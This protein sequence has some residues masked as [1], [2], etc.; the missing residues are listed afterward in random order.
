MNLA[1]RRKR[2]EAFGSVRM[3]PSRRDRRFSYIIRPIPTYGLKVTA[4]S[5]IHAQELACNSNSPAVPNPPADPSLPARLQLE[6]R[7]QSQIRLQTPSL[8]AHLSSPANPVRLLARLQTQ[9]RLQSQARLQTQFA[10]KLACRPKSACSPKV[11]CRLSSPASSPADPSLP[12]VL[13]S[14]ADPSC[15]LASSLSTAHLEYGNSYISGQI[16][17]I[18][19]EGTILQA[20]QMAV[21]STN[22]RTGAETACTL[23]NAAHLSC[24]GEGTR[25]ANARWLVRST[26]AS[27]SRCHAYEE[28]LSH[29]YV[30]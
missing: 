13:S 4:Y 10:C 5:S 27:D 23:I 24:P 9:V 12:A 19:G 22:E 8:P 7:L 3:A 26:Q 30:A 21:H 20:R 25:A 2:T 1:K 18:K 29:S 17:Q 14:P 15:R 6:I 28:G 16:P 11:A